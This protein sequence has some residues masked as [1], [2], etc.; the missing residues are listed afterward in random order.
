MG[1]LTITFTE[2][3]PPPVGGYRVKYK[4]LGTTTYSMVSP[5]PTSS[6]VVI[7]DVID[8][9]AYEGSIR[10]DC[11]SNVAGSEV[12]FVAYAN[13]A[14]TTSYGTLL[15]ACDADPQLIYIS[16]AYVDIAPGVAVY[17]DQALSILL[18]SPVAIIDQSGN[19]FNIASGIVG[20]DTGTDC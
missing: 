10:S 19:I 11:G 15:S 2:T 18:T 1:I 8:N 7:S 12:N 20:T 13:T 5:N 4:K 16:S 3:A 9:T 14:L 6:P 17:T